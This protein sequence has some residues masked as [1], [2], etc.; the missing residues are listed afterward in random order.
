MRLVRFLRWAP[1]NIGLLLLSVRQAGLTAERQTV[2]L[3]KGQTWK[4]NWHARPPALTRLRSYNAVN[5]TTQLDCTIIRSVEPPAST[6]LWPLV[7]STCR[8]P[9]VERSKRISDHTAL[10][11]FKLPIDPYVSALSKR[12]FA[13]FYK[14]LLRESQFKDNRLYML[15]PVDSDKRDASLKI[16]YVI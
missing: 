14:F 13:E 9:D 10:H 16:R 8:A 2:R 12:H 1:C 3:M 11:K 4:N 15:R 5:S 6:H 7:V